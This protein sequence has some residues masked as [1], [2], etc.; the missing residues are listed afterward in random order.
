M[1]TS[2]GSQPGSQTDKKSKIN[3]MI[4]H[5][6][7]IYSRKEEVEEKGKR[8]LYNIY[9]RRT[10]S[11]YVFLLSSIHNSSDIIFFEFAQ[12][13]RETIFCLAMSLPTDA[14]PQ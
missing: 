12:A 4:Y 14:W 2:S 7:K 5:L 9:F 10:C 3:C 11:V 13:R 6:F 1:G 8:S